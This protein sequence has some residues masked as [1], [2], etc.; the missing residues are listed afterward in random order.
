MPKRSISHKDKLFEDLQ[1]PIFAAEYFNA[2]LE[3]GDMGSILL[4][5]KNLVEARGGMTKIAEQT[6]LNR[7][8]LYRSLSENGNPKLSTFYK[9]LDAVGVKLVAKPQNGRAA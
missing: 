7:E 3:D 1:D 5:V 8:S 6:G 4:C 2:V 9:I